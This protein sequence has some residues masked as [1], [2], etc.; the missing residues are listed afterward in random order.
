MQGLGRKKQGLKVRLSN[1][2]GRGSKC[3]GKEKSMIYGKTRIASTAR[4]AREAVIVGDVTIGEKSSVWYYSVLRGDES[5]ITIGNETN[6]QENCMIH[7]SHDHPAV[8]GDGVTVGHHAILHSCKVGDGSLIGM[9]AIL[10]DGAEIGQE[11]LVAAG[12]LVTGKTKVPD[13]SMVMGSP[14]KVVRK[15]TEEE[16]QGL[17]E[18]RETY[19]R[20]AEQLNMEPN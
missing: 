14:A 9:G 6:I 17:R 8:V 2:P 7:V 18:S 4:I 10:L 3:A 13:G 11:C 12:S 20:L 19:V 1:P 15:L 5:S 16:K